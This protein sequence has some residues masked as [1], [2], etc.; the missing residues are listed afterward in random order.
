MKNAKKCGELAETLFAAEIMRRGGVPSKPLGDSTPYDWL[1]HV[2]KKIWRVQV[3]STWHCVIRKGKRSASKCRVTIS[4]G[5]YAKTVYTKQA[6]DFVA[7]YVD[8]FSS[9]IIIPAHEIRGRKT[10]F[11]GRSDC[12]Q[13][14]WSLL[15]L[16]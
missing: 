6:I 3:K 7:I 14:S 13:P 9:W 12:E 4:A 2:G 10:V 8:P 5:N 15:G 16:A 11:I 1:V